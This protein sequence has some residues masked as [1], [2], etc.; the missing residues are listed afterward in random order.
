MVAS[1]RY[2]IAVAGGP[3]KGMDRSRAADAVAETPDAMAEARSAAPEA[4]AASI[5]P[6]ATV[7]AC[8]HVAAILLQPVPAG[9]NRFLAWQTAAGRLG[10][11]IGAWGRGDDA[12]QQPL[13]PARSISAIRLSLL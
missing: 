12:G 2:R 10:P 7:C 6:A 11:W 4:R 1:S 9:E 13:R 3:L 8:G 5:D